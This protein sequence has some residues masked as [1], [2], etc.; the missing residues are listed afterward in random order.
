MA[1]INQI[2]FNQLVAGNGGNTLLL[3]D[4]QQTILVNQKPV[5]LNPLVTPIVSAN[6]FTANE[7]ESYSLLD[8]TRKTTIYNL[9]N[10]L[11]ATAIA[12]GVA[13]T[14]NLFNTSPGTAAFMTHTPSA[15]TDDGP[16]LTVQDGYTF[17]YSQVI[18]NELRPVEAPK[19]RTTQG[20]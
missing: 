16:A 7:L 11:V 1:I 19:P 15:T 20:I 13:I 9:I 12:S 18:A 2:L 17:G 14:T 5:N 8:A 3:V 6:T 10:A 4:G